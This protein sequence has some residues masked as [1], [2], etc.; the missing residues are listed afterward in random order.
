MHAHAAMGKILAARARSTHEADKG[1]DEV[2]GLPEEALQLLLYALTNDGSIHVRRAAMTVLEQVDRSSF[3]PQ[4]L[5]ECQS[6][7]MYCMQTVL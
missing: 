2:E 1:A 5:R 6:R 3:A 7:M 4:C